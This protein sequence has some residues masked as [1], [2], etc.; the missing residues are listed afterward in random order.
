[1]WRFAPGGGGNGTPSP[2][3]R[4]T[5]SSPVFVNDPMQDLVSLLL[6]TYAAV[7]RMAHGIPSYYQTKS[8]AFD[9]RHSLLSHLPQRAPSPPPLPSRYH[10]GDTISSPLLRRLVAIAPCLLQRQ[11]NCADQP[12]WA[13]QLGLRRFRTTRTVPYGERGAPCALCIFYI[14]IIYLTLFFCSVVAP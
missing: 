6:T 2:A 13:F 8:D 12:S 9:C 7:A 5:D 10:F 3:L 11:C 1:M 14:Q 4:A